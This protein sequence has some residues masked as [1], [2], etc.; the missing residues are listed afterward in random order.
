MWSQ[1]E[2]FEAHSWLLVMAGAHHQSAAAVKFVLA[3]AAAQPSVSKVF[4]TAACASLPSMLLP[5]LLLHLRRNHCCCRCWFQL[6]STL[7]GIWQ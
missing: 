1:E 6:T 3:L 7:E 5:V 2:Y 4:L